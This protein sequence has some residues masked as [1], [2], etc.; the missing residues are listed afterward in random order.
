MTTL[1]VPLWPGNVVVFPGQLCLLQG[2]GDG[3]DLG[4]SYG[5]TSPDRLR[6]FRDML[7]FCRA[8]E[9]RLGL[10]LA[11]GERGRQL[12]PVGTLVDWVEDDARPRRPDGDLVHGSLVAGRARFRLLNLYQD[13]AFLEG[14]VEIWPWDEEPA[15]DWA[16][17]EQV[18]RYLHRY[19]QAFS[20]LM[21]P[22]WLPD[23]LEPGP[24]M[25]GM[26]AGAIVQLPPHQKQRLLATPTVRSLLRHLVPYLRWQVPVA[27]RLASMAPPSVDLATLARLN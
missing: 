3:L 27:E 9:S 12:A 11:T 22:A 23:L 26:L 13:R 24:V 5:G 15:P 10:V 4:G 14:L 2:T 20:D 21:P 1:R 17:I 6:V 18:G 8:R 7:A 25:L 19:G 16:L